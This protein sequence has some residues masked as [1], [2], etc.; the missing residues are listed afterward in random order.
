MSTPSD[1]YS[2]GE[3]NTEQILEQI[4]FCGGMFTEGL[5]TDTVPVWF[6]A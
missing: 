6:V 5:L 2:I 1:R 4:V 3:N